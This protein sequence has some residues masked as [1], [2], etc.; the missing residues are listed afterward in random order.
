M[1][2][3]TTFYGYSIYQTDTYLMASFPWHPG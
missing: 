3:I 2:Y 1:W